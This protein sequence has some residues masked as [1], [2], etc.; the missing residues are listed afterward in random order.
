MCGVLGGVFHRPV[1]PADQAAFQRAIRALEHRGPDDEMVSVIPEANAILAF[2]RLSIID[3]STGQQP[4][5]TGAGHHII[6]NGEIYNY[7]DLRAGHQ[8]AGVPLRTRSDTEVLLWQ[9]VRHGHAG[10]QALVGMFGFV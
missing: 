6:F 10:L 4:M 7:H 9:L 8:K 5:S 1:T 2:R 3:L